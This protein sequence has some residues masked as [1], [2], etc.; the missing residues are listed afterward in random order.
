M[1]QA[2]TP[3]YLTSGSNFPHYEATSLYSISESG[4]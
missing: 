3:K 1:P 4:L 2:A